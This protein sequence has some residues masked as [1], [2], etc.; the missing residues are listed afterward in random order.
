M[1][2]QVEEE[3]LIIFF[4]NRIKITFNRI[5]IFFAITSYPNIELHISL[6]DFIVTNQIINFFSSLL[7]EMHTMIPIFTHF[8]VMYMRL[9]K[10][11][12]AKPIKTRF[13][14][15]GKFS[16]LFTRFFAILRKAFRQE[17]FYDD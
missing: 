7:C 11:H 8:C 17:I 1:R 3:K 9:A 4:I 2:N 15:W 10:K 6:T 13:Q 5:K 16:S 14:G 12:Y